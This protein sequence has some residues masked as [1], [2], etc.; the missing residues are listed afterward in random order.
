MRIIKMISKYTFLPILALLTLSSSAQKTP[1]VSVGSA[2]PPIKIG[3]V[4]YNLLDLYEGTKGSEDIDLYGGKGEY[5]KFD[6]AYGLL[7]EIPLNYKSSLDMELNMG[8]MT[9]QKENQYLK[10]ELSMFNVHYRR[11]LTKSQKSDKFYTRLYCQLGLGLTLYK[12]E[13]YF[14]K[15]NGLFSM[16]E[17]V[18]FNNSATIGCMFNLSKKFQVSLSTGGMF[19]YADGFDGYDNQKAG[20]LMLKSGL[21]LYFS[22]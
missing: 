15:D 1:K 16:R 12:A 21:G 4:T 14:V 9:S 11:Y 2:K 5:T 10:T 3:I 13:R 7:V 22:L 18:C 6:M 19:N 8:K 17:G 20:D